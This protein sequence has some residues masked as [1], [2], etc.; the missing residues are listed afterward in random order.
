MAQRDRKKTLTSLLTRRDFIKGSTIAAAALTLKPPNIFADTAGIVSPSPKSIV[1]ISE[2]LKSITDDYKIDPKR[3][4]EMIDE[5][6]KAITNTKSAK[7][8]WL[9]IF[10]NLKEKE[11]IGLKPNTINKRIPAH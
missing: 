4:R 5:G 7:E 2:N 11:V 8:G 9:K 3:V 10:P 1:A 6:I